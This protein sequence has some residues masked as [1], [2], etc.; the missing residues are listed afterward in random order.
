MRKHGTQNTLRLLRFGKLFPVILLLEVSLGVTPKAA[1]FVSGQ[2]PI[3]VFLK[4]GTR[5]SVPKSEILP[6]GPAVD[7]IPAL[8]YPKRVSAKKADAFLSPEDEVLG[9]VRNG[10]AV[11]YPIRLLNWHEI[12]N[13]EV[14]GIPI[15]ATYCPLCKSGIVF[16]RRLDGR[17]ME[18][19]VSGLLYKSDLILYDRETKSLWSQIL[20]QAITGPSI[21]KSLERLPGVQTSW[22]MW[23]EKYPA[24]EVASFQTGYARDYLRDPYRGYESSE[25]LYFPVGKP[26]P[27]LHPKEIVFG[28]VSGTSTLA[29]PVRLIKTKGKIPAALGK[30]R[31]T[32]AYEEGVRARKQ[33]GREIPG[34]IAY[35]FAWSAF[36]PK[37]RILPE[38]P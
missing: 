17:I 16:D 37:T 13:D 12:A 22:K 32:L 2:D 1:D 6:G 34:V 28:V 20:S 18:F 30:D 38:S 3:E 29:A 23:K 33:D 4:H 7:G 35:W 11:A 31:I 27:R 24:T 10:Q 14:G 5:S 8:K 36:H 19:G 21:G 25:R 15:A 26:D 9:V